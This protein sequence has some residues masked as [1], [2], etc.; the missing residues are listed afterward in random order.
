MDNLRHLL[1]RPRDAYATW[2]DEQWDDQG[3][4]FSNIDALDKHGLVQLVSPTRYLAWNFQPLLDSRGTIEFRRPYQSLGYS[5]AVHWVTITLGL[6]S[7]FL[8]LDPKHVSN[9]LDDGLLLSFCKYSFIYSLHQRSSSTLV[10]N[11]LRQRCLSTLVII[12]DSCHRPSIPFD[13]YRCW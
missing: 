7:M 3:V 2:N 4:D 8:R 9:D 12:V 11:A 6:F 1:P 13:H 5:H 10:I